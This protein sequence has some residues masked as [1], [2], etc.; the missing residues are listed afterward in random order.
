LPP[1]V[2]ASA[3]CII[4]TGSAGRVHGSRRVTR[5]QCACTQ[6]VAGRRAGVIFSQVGGAAAHPGD[7]SH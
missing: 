4:P 5:I 1:S 2:P 7:E 6:G 3:R